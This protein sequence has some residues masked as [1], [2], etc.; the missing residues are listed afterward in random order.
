MTR[1]RK[2]VTQCLFGIA[3]LLACLAVCEWAV[4]RFGRT[5]LFLFG[6]QP[7]RLLEVAAVILLFVITL[8]LSEAGRPTGHPK[9]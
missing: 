3:T 2:L 8:Q 7:F 4:E 6:Y 5:L 1:L 9:E